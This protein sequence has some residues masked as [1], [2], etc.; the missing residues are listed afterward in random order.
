[1]IDV[2]QATPSPIARDRLSIVS[3]M[4]DQSEPGNVPLVE[5]LEGDPGADDEDTYQLDP[6]LAGAK[7]T[8]GVLGSRRLVDLAREIIEIG[9]SSHSPFGD[10]IVTAGGR[11]ADLAAEARRRLAQDRL[12][13]DAGTPEQQERRDEADD[14]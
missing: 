1:M 14:L 7:G 2:Y 9:R 3:V 6:I 10:C 8:L 11:V 4:T 12:P 5:A 13:D